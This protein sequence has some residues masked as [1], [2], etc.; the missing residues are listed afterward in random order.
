MK[1]FQ[2]VQIQDVHVGVSCIFH[3]VFD[4]LTNDLGNTNS[5][6]SDTYSVVNCLQLEG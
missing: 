4:V 6:T 2:R 1:A 3:G 5:D